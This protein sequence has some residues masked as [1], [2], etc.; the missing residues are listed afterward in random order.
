M[1]ITYFNSASTPTDGAS[2]T[3]TATTTAVTPPGSMATGDLVILYA[4]QRGSASMSILATGG[5]TWSEITNSP[6]ASFSN[7]SFKVFWCRY[8]GTWGANPSV[9]FSAGTCTT[10][11]MH[12]YRPTTGTNLWAVE[13]EYHPTGPFTPVGGTNVCDGLLNSSGTTQN[14]TNAST[15]TVCAWFTSDD[16]TWGLAT[17]SNWTNPGSLQYRNTSG[18]DQSI[19]FAHNIRTT[20]GTLAVPSR[21]QATL[22]ADNYGTSTI[23]FYEYEPGATN[24]SAFFAFF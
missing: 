1:A 15:V 12:V 11:V 24:N 6:S 23:I 8:N 14:T 3:N 21:A 7:Q 9:L 18:S 2:A 4:Q 22:G 16:N 13:H 19:A 10:V 20:A 17:G 5:Q